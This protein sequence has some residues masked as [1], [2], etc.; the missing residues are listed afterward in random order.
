MV[1]ES[2]AIFL[3]SSE[4]RSLVV[5]VEARGGL[6][7]TRVVFLAVGAAGLELDDVAVI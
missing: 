3:P 7:Q 4:R 6:G 5:S 1:A 2:V